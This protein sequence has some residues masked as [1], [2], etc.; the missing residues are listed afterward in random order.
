M[1]TFEALIPLFAAL[2]GGLAVGV[3]VYLVI[4]SAGSSSTRVRA[5]ISETQRE[6][7]RTDLKS[8][9]GLLALGMPMLPV[10]MP[11]AR[12]L[13]LESLKASLAE[14]YA[15]AGWPG[16]LSDEEVYAMSL[17]LGFALAIPVAL[18]LALLHPLA[19]LLGLVFVIL[20]PGLVSSSYGSAGKRRDQ[21]IDR[22]MPFVLDLLT[23]TMRAGASLT[24]AM[25]R[26]T[27]DYSDH[28]IGAEFR[29]TLMDIEL[30]ST[31]KKAFQNF[32]ARTPLPVI[33]SF[34]DDLVQSEELGRP[35]AETLERLSD[36]MRVRRVQDAMDTAGRAKVM[37]LI[38]GMLVFVATLILLFSPF[39]VRF[40][41]GGYTP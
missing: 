17:L 21:A 14:R 16:G 29:Y 13:P 40:Y 35:I 25:G 7:R 12:A 32:A 15:Y 31:T 38:P 26:V 23:L 41:Y 36:R 30:G 39:A 33:K 9:Q 20:G 8:Q 22:T 4:S 1:P 10:M 3:A 34:V 11:I 5:A 37:V 18:M 24:I 6:L 2:L 19:A 28:P 27:A